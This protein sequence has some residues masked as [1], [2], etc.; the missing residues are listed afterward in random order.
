[1]TRRYGGTI[2]DVLLH[3]QQTRHRLDELAS[4]ATRA[5]DLE[6]EREVAEVALAAAQGVVGRA[7]R[8]AAPKLAEAVETRLRTLA[9]PRARLDVVVGPDDP[10]DDVT[11]LLGANPG[12]PLLPLSKVA[13]GGELARTM[14]AL[15]LVVVADAP[16][17]MV[18]D[19]VDAGIGGEAALAVG[20]A[21]AAVGRQHQVLV[22][23]HL[24]QVAAFADQQLAVT[25][26]LRRSRIVAAVRALDPEA[27]VVE[28]ARML[29]GTPASTTARRH[30]VELLESASGA[31]VL[32]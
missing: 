32:R 7:R 5:A 19:E 24:A 26:R 28:L 20:Q 14:L 18:F 31:R 1:L 9:L 29:S 16:P 12:E 17:T 13:S 10:G 25:K 22:V 21:L 23:T 27:R 3:A 6:R 11:F 30:A 8:L 15:R 4:A 2:A